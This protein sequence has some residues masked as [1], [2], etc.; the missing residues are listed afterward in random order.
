MNFK[1]ENFIFFK[2]EYKF[3]FFDHFTVSQSDIKILS[4]N[5]VSHEEK[6]NLLCFDKNINLDN[7]NSEEEEKIKCL[8]DEIK[9]MKK[10]DMENLLKNKIKIGKKDLNESW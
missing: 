8:V 5:K 9:I 6:N 10:S 7:K 3:N 4:N 2:E 1:C